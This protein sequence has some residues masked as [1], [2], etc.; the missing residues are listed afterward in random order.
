MQIYE[1]C[2]FQDLTGQRISNVLGIMTMLEDR[3]GDMLDRFSTLIGGPQV[4]QTAT[5][6]AK[7]ELLNGPKLDDDTGHASQTD[8]DALFD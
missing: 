3:I 4:S 6:A 7:R 5:P 8:I 1:A 2:N